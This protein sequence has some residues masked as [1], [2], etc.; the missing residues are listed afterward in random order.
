MPMTLNVRI[1]LAG[2]MFCIFAAMVGMASTYP[3]NAAFVPLV[4]GVPGTV[5]C[6]IQL[7]VELRTARAGRTTAPAR[8]VRGEWLMFA[9]LFGFVASVILF[10]FLVAAPFVLFAY[11]RFKAKAPYW[12]CGLIALG[13]LALVYGVFEYTLQVTLFEGLLTPIV[14]SWLGLS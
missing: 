8:D 10:G 2:L 12:L 3:A 14:T 11:L 13:G 5:L 9:W 6:L 1:I 7:G 4:I